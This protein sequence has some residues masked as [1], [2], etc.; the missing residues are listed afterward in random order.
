MITD[1]HLVEPQINTLLHRRP[2]VTSICSVVTTVLDDPWLSLRSIVVRSVVSHLCLSRRSMVE[3]DGDRVK[4]YVL[5][6]CRFFS[7]RCK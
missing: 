2:S 4:E 3:V 6:F 1:Y 7:D 5:L